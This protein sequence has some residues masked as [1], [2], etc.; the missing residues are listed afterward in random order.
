M[1]IVHAAAARGGQTTGTTDRGISFTPGGT[2]R[3]Y[4]LF[5]I[6]ANNTNTSMTCSDSL[7]GTWSLLDTTLL[8]ASDEHIAAV[9]IRDILNPTTDG[10]TVTVASGANE[11]GEI[12]T[13]SVTG[14]TRTGLQA[15][16]QWAKQTKQAG[17]GT[18]AP[19]FSA[20]CSTTS[21]TCGAVMNEGGSLTPPTGWTERNDF[22]QNTPTIAME[23]I[24]RD[25]GFTGTTVTW[26]STSA[27]NFVSWILELDDSPPPAHNQLTLT[28]CG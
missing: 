17:G 13:L 23:T 15:V 18:P 14:C 2:D 4:M 5:V 9:F 3:L 25:S 10:M 22:G 21:Y 12:H 24:S 11:A 1:A 6:L 20:A 7:G 26:G 16:K 27:T 19:S 8:G 28:G